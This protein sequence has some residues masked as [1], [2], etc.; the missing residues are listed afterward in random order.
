MSE[1]K[2]I[3]PLL[4][5]FAMGDPMSSHHGV[6]CCPAMENDSDKKY[7]VKVI[8]IPASQVQLEALLLTG[9]Y[10]SDAAALS[11]FRELAEG[12]V[13][14][15]KIL[16]KLSK[17]EGFLPY[18]SWQIVQMDNAVGYDVYLLSSYKRSLERFFR[19]ESMTQLGAVNLGLDLCAA[20]AVCRRMGMLYVDLKP[21]NVYISGDNEYRVGDL[22]FVPLTSL[23]YASLPD[24]Y[25][26]VYTPPEIKDAYSSLNETMD[27]YAIGMILYQA[28]NNGQLPFETQRPQEPLPPPVYA[29]Y[30]MAEIIMKAIAMDP[31]E[32]WQDP[33]TMG[34]AL[35]SYMQRNGA[36]DT[37]L[38]VSHE[39][40]PE[41]KNEEENAQEPSADAEEVKD[42]SE[43]DMDSGDTLEESA[44]S[45]S[46]NAESGADVPVEESNEEAEDVSELPDQ[47]SEDPELAEIM[48]IVGT[49]DNPPPEETDAEPDAADLSFMEKM[50]SDETAPTED[51]V[52]QVSYEELTEDVSDILAQ[53][54]ELISHETPAPAV[55]PDPVEI[56]MPDPIPIEEEAEE[57]TTEEKETD[58]EEAAQD[59]A[60]ESEASDEAEE[61]G[62]PE[63]PDVQPEPK[64]KERSPE[65]IAHRKQTVKRIVVSA[66]TVI[67]VAALMF[68][69]YYY[70]QNFY[71]RSVSELTLTG[72]ENQL[73]VQ[74]VSNA[75]ESQL[76]VVCTD[77]YG[78]KLSVPVENGQATFENLKP[79]TL[80]TVSVEVEGFHKLSG[81]L[82]ESYTTPAETDIVTFEATTGN[83][84]G[85]VILQ[86]T[87]KGREPE[88]WDVVYW[89]EGE[90]EKTLAVSNHTI[91]VTGLTP[92]KTYTFRL[93]SNSP[94][95]LVG[96]SEITHTVV[97]P[98]YAQNLKIVSSDEDGLEVRWEIPEGLEGTSWQVHCYN[99]SGY[100]QY[101]T[102]SENTALFTDTDSDTEY[103][104]EVVA[105]GMSS[106]S[107][108][109]VTKNAVR[110]SDFLADTSDPATINLSWDYTGNAPEG[111]WLVLYSVGTSTEQEVVR[112]DSASAKISPAAPGIVYHITIQTAD[113]VTVFNDT[114]Q[115]D[116]PEAE[117]FDKYQVTA[118]DF[119]LDMCLTPFEGDWSYTDLTDESYTTE[120]TVGQKASFLASLETE[121]SSADEYVTTQFLIKD[122]EGNAVSANSDTRVWGDMWYEGHCE[123]D[124][125][126]LPDQPGEYTVE[127]YF[128]GAYA[129]Q[130]TFTVVAAE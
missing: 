42:I 37:P 125:P 110:V 47:E 87:V 104:V 33:I 103:T 66:V 21:G 113:G 55:A 19:K 120:F 95:Y 105:E 75:D 59:E 9:A 124:I 99:E 122:H 18:E 25:R 102:T 114:H 49:E 20:M 58:A 3:S 45:E 128:D 56:P 130:Q 57:E 77:T 8:S 80:Y 86:F 41:Q 82:T 5:N 63:E 71:L 73:V 72:N 50:T 52:Q 13:K 107:R 51:I 30:E 68:G 89:T 48:K 40:T 53:A 35:V 60:C 78:Q 43:T 123:L 4:D 109:H 32:R 119:Q 34:Q 26:S 10:N 117:K 88:S 44:V 39:K 12:V 76:S 74:V 14:E 67:L 31:A 27:I 29:D 38:A 111:G 28:Y 46:E 69:V 84:E 70:Y 83:Q 121:Y 96:Q 115:V 23:K 6:R 127:I 24:K 15:A 129:G 94:V 101:I 2:L 65:E 90:E 126:K 54:D 62:K 112:T 100:D 93:N 116:T 7:I 16:Q 118:D 92:G 106:G 97:A 91:T 85:A 11:Y 108:T 36:N 79:N 61:S 1:P 81:K 64:K 22:G 17:L 98:V